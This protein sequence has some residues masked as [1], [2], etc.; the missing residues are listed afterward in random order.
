MGRINPSP[1]DRGLD[2]IGALTEEGIGESQGLTHELCY[3]SDRLWRHLRE[4]HGATC[5][6][7][8]GEGVFISFKGFRCSG[9]DNNDLLRSKGF[10]RLCGG[11]VRAEAL[12]PFQ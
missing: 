7:M 3:G 11:G 8:S 9:I 5:F 10:A 6:E 1:R 4:D 2:A 12:E